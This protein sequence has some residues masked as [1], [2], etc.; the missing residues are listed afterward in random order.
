MNKLKI[1]VID[2]DITTCNLLKTVLQ[3][4]NYE[5]VASSSIKDGDILWLLNKEQPEIL[6]LDFHL[7]AEDAL[8]YLSVI[9]V[10]A[11]WKSLPILVTSAIDRRR[12]CLAAGANDFVLKPFNWEEI[13]GIVNKLRDNSVSSLEK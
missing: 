13:T 1:L 6:I 11:D 8:E 5:A 3:M 7:G 10:D 12:D 9:R 2:D 4:E